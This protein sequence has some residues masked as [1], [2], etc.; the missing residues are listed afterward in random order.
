M[1][2]RPSFFFCLECAL[3]CMAGLLALLTALWPDWIERVF[4]VDP[5]RHSGSIEW[6]F[7]VALVAVA[8]L[9]RHEWSRASGA[10]TRRERF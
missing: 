7:I 8:A 3:G 10:L 2:R 5:D 1:E 4:V 9:A 6:E